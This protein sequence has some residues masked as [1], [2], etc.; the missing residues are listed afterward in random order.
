MLVDWNGSE[1]G[2]PEPTLTDLFEDAGGPH[3]RRHR[4]HLRGRPRCRT[5][6]STRGPAGWPT[7]WPSTAPAPSGFVAL[8]LPRSAGHDRGDRSPC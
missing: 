3:A 4:R 7:G 6:N 8:A 5:P 1:H 2:R